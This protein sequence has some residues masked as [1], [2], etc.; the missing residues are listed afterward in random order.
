MMAELRRRTSD[1]RERCGEAGCLSDSDPCHGDVKVD[2]VEK[3]LDG[4]HV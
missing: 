3:T 1:S 2:V 4:Q